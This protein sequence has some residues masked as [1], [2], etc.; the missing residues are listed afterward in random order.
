[1]EYS[2]AQQ[3]ENAMPGDSAAIIFLE[4]YRKKEGVTETESGLMYE[5]FTEGKGL[6]PRLQDSIAVHYKGTLIDGTVF[7]SSYD[8]NNP[9]VFVL[10]G[11]IPGWQEGLMQMREGAV[12]RLVI[13]A[14]LGYGFRE[15]GKIPPGSILVFDV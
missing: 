11:L 5:I 3:S 4:K 7:D 13:P 1:W 8:K 9:Q 10:S 12:F 6:Q 14:Y 2:L 15:M